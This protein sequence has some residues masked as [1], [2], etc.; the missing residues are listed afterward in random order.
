MLFPIPGS[1]SE[2]RWL[3]SIGRGVNTLSILDIITLEAGQTVTSSL[4][5]SI[6][7]GADSNAETIL[8][9]EASVG[10]SNTLLSRPCFAKEVAFGNN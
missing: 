10:A 5:E 1:T 9:G 6:A 7:V 2:V 8:I 3:S 4:I